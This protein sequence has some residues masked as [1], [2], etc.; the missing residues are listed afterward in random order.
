[1]NSNRHSSDG[2]FINKNEAPT[3]FVGVG[4]V[5]FNKYRRFLYE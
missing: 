1:M 3:L 5:Y 4:G 2:F